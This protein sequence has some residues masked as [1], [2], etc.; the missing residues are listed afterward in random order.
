MNTGPPR[1]FRG[2][3]RV[4]GAL[5][6][7]RQSSSNPHVHL[8][9]SLP[10]LTLTLTA[11]FALTFTQSMPIPDP[12]GG[13]PNKSSDHHYRSKRAHAG[14]LCLTVTGK[15]KTKNARTTQFIVHWSPL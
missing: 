2:E 1:G 15:E 6:G 4:G 7:S 10:F 13:G 8:G 9:S 14:R 11:I 12:D 3:F 5:T